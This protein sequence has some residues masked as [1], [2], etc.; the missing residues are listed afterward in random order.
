M[1]LDHKKRSNLMLL[2]YVLELYLDM[3]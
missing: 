3:M 1:I 2:F